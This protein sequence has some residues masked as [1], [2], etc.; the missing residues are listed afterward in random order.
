[1]SYLVIFG[2]FHFRPETNFH[3]CNIFRFPSK[4][5]ICIGPKMSCS[6][7][8]RNWVLWCTGDFR[9]RFSAEKGISFSSALSFTVE[10]EK[11]IFGR[12]P[13]QTVLGYT[14]RQWFSNIQQSRFWT[15]CRCLEKLVLRSIFDTSSF[16]YYPVSEMTYTVSSGTLNPTIPYH[17]FVIIIITII[18]VA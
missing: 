13:H 4:N 16:I 7:L 3:F 9:F 5:V 1:M 6:Q 14:L 10:D 8:N 12:P 17:S 2:F 11:C 15:A 18:V